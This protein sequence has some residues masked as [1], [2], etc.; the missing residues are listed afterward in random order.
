MRCR[1]GASSLHVHSSTGLA[2][3][4]EE[5]WESRGAGRRVH[6]AAAAANQPA[7]VHTCSRRLDTL[8]AS[9]HSR[10]PTLAGSQFLCY[11]VSRSPEKRARCPRCH[12]SVLCARQEA[13]SLQVCPG[14]RW[15]AWQ[16]VR[17]TCSWRPASTQ[18]A[19]PC[20]AA[21]LCV[22]QDAHGRWT[23]QVWSMPPA[24]A[25]RLGQRGRRTVGM[26][27]AAHVLTCVWPAA[28]GA[29]GWAV[30]EAQGHRLGEAVLG[31][32]L[33]GPGWAAA[34]VPPS[35]ASGPWMP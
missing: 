3:R 17:G 4:P 5:P 33:P 22:V 26:G 29:C 28:S 9:Q 31:R 21:S 25:W 14:A 10:T 6:S 34:A 19:A 23:L 15:P 13:A 16:Q 2:S 12:Q 20:W 8:N 35:P 11:H 30:P 24:R 7:S 1:P 32:A 18:Q 27:P